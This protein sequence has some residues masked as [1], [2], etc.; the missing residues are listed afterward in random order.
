[1]TATRT[2]ATTKP[3]FRETVASPQFLLKMAS[4]A[5]VESQGT[6]QKVEGETVTVRY[7]YQGHHIAKGKRFDIVC[8]LKQ[9]RKVDGRI[10]CNVLKNKTPI[11]DDYHRIFLYNYVMHGWIELRHDTQIAMK[12]G[13]SRVDILIDNL[14]QKCL[15]PKSRM[16]NTFNKIQNAGQP[17]FSIGIFQGKTAHNVVKLR[18]VATQFSATSIFV[19]H[20]RYND[21]KPFVEA[22]Q[23]FEDEKACP[24]V[25][26]LDFNDF[27]S[28]LTE[29]WVLVGVEM[30]GTPLSKFDH[31]R[32][33]IY[34]LG[35]EDNGL[36]ALAQK[37][38]KHIIE[39]PSVRSESFN[40]TCAGA[41][42]MYDRFSKV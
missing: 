24:L 25:E 8:D 11:N 33:A 27:A 18:R 42:V 22:Q 17:E 31:P 10:I 41:I 7:S 23:I 16:Y 20:P 32:K 3:R 1:M 36:S 12:E 26:Y 6:C 13:E 40:V 5:I 30:G 14:F 38:C 15:N 28:K 4:L 9:S 19:I 21:R 35:A 37:A 39:I 34:M 29:G 2:N